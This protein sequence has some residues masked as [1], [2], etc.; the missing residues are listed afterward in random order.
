MEVI[1]DVK[2]CDYKSDCMMVSLRTVCIKWCD[3]IDVK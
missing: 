3:E 2:L 1:I